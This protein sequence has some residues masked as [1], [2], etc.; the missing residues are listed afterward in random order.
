L[1][2]RTGPCWALAVIPASNSAFI[3]HADFSI[4]TFRVL[5]A[6]STCVIKA[7]SDQTII[8]YFTLYTKEIICADSICAVT[9]SQTF[10]TVLRVADSIR[11]LIIS[12]AFYTGGIG[13]AM[14]CLSISAVIINNTLETS[15]KVADSIRTMFVSCALYTSGIGIANRRF[16]IS[17][18]TVHNALN[19]RFKV[20]D[21]IRALFISVAFYTG[22]IGIAHRSF[23]TCTVIINN[24]FNTC[25]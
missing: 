25:F 23:S 16:S 8:I 19:T 13:I 1:I 11:T 5:L 21:T 18:V 15:F 9:I 17:A 22:G 4:T 6:T 3:I 2:F 10:N 24:T 12:C 7:E 14:R 20:T